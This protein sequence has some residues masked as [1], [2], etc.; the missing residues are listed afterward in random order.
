M[1]DPAAMAR[2]FDDLAG[3]YDNPHHDEVAQAL[4]EFAAAGA[5]GDAE[6]A[7]G[8]SGAVADVAC[9]TGAVA[10]AV[11]RLRPAAAAPVLAIDI[12]AGMVAAG[13]A[14]AARSGLV[15]GVDWRIGP[16]VPL[17]VADAS[18]DI[19]LCASSLHFLGARALVDSRR[20]LRPGGRL[21]FT[22]PVAS[23]S[24]P[25]GVFADLVAADLPLPRTA[26]D[27]A[28]VARSAG[29]LDARA[30]VLTVGPREA[31]LVTAHRGA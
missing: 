28:E 18:L 23:R 11:A 17:P 24:R 19:I 8:V 27:A 16:A 5:A 29:F 30:R 12:S 13:R 1:T 3:D 9:G 21:G 20:A 6:T 26:G 15:D 7:F 22:L 10:L 4:V 2:A 31:V 14:R 25:S